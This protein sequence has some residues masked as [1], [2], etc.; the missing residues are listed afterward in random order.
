M[1]TPDKCLIVIFFAHILTSVYIDIG[2]ILAVNLSTVR[3]WPNL[4]I[5]SEVLR[6]QGKTASVGVCM[7][8]SMV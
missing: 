6:F 4:T 5:P 2:L 7:V 1:L 8:W 3:L